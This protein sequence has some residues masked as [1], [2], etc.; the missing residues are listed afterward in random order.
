MTIDIFFIMLGLFLVGIAIGTYMSRRI[1]YYKRVRMHKRQARQAREIHEHYQW[2]IDKLSQ[3]PPGSAERYST[4]QDIR[5]MRLPGE[6]L[7]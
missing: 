5:K 4:L 7:Q 1:E 2:L 3:Y 6:K